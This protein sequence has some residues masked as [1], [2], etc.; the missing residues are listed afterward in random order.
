MSYQARNI[1]VLSIFIIL[2]ILVGGYLSFY[3]YPKK[4]D[5]LTKQI[6]NLDRQVKGISGVDAQIKVVEKKL[7]E[8][9]KKLASLDKVVLPNVT[10]DMTY[11]YLNRIL[12]YAGVFKFDMV[13]SRTRKAKNYSYNVYSIKGEGYFDNIYNFVWYLE[14]GPYIYR[15]KKLS[16]RGVERR[17]KETQKPQIIVPFEMELHA[18]YANIKDLPPVKRNLSDVRVRYVRNPFLPYIFRNL[19]PNVEGLVDVE[20]AEL[21]ALLPGK[22]FIVDHNG[23]LHVLKEGDRVYLGYLTKIDLENNQVEFTLNKGGIV[24]KFVLKLSFEKTKQ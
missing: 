12:N 15:I 20:R 23:Q 16:L 22:A 1:L 21:K 24:E 14:R 17:D 9:E 2:I 10:P 3:H 6:K 7:K 19:P 18:L 4:I 5:K 8:W 11:A 13:Y